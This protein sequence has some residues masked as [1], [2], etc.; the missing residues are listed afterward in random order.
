MSRLILSDRARASEA[1]A[2]AFRAARRAVVF[3][4]AGVS[5]ESGIPDFRSPGGIWSR[6]KPIEY[7]EF[8]SSEAARLEDWQRRFGMARLLS[9]C[10]PNAAHRAVA[11]L[12]QQGI[13][14][15]VVTQNIDG[16]HARAGVPPD[17]LVELHGTAAHASCLDCAERMEIPQAQRIVEETG[18]SPR[19]QACGGL[20][21]AAVV[22]FGQAMPEAEMQKAMEASVAADLFIAAG[23]SLVVYPAAA[24]PQIAREAGARLIVAN[25]EPTEQDSTADIVIRTPLAETFAPLQNMK[26]A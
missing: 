6:M 7:Q 22:S 8:L 23:S 14:A 3:T 16:L 11:R 26:F 19:C 17:R 20:V 4:G 5:T 21:K 18:A 13:V 25:R 15:M 9:E 1:L 10:E 24:F 2:E 12:V